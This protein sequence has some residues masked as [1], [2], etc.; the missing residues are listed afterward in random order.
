MDLTR[1]TIGKK[2]MI[3]TCIHVASYTNLNSNP[4]GF[5]GNPQKYKLAS[6]ALYIWLYA[7][8]CQ[9][10]ACISLIPKSTWYWGVEIHWNL[11]G[12][13][14]IW[15]DNRLIDNRVCLKMDKHTLNVILYPFK[16]YII[17]Y[18]QTS[19]HKQPLPQDG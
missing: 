12:I 5:I 7:T 9:A 8:S 2:Y 13:M 10:L 16:S 11:M 18:A 1:D 4:V 19:M 6:V 3:I 17:L 15:I 14:N